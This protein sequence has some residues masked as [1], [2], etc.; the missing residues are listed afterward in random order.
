MTHLPRVWLVLVDLTGDHEDVGV[1]VDVV[2][3]PAS[4]ARPTDLSVPDDAPGGVFLQRALDAG[5]GDVVVVTTTPPPPSTR[6]RVARAFLRDQ[7]PTSLGL[8]DGGQGLA[9][10][11][12]TVVVDPDLDLPTAGA[13]LVRGHLELTIPEAGERFLVLVDR[14]PDL[15]AR[16]DRPEVELL[17]ALVA[18]WPQIPLVLLSSEQARPAVTAPWRDL[19][20]EV[21]GDCPDWGPWFAEHRL[22]FSTVFSVSIR[23]E[24]RF[25]TFLDR[26]QPVAN[27]VLLAHA[28]DSR[29]VLSMEPVLVVREE[30]RGLHGLV[31]LLR[32]RVATSLDRAD[33]VLVATADDRRQ[34]QGL[35]PTKRVVVL[36]D[37]LAGAPAPVRERSDLVVLASPGADTLA[38]HEDAAVLA[39]REVL[40]IVRAQRPGTTLR[41]LADNPSPVV[42]LL[43]QEPGVVVEPLGHDPVGSVASAR[44]LLAPYAH[45]DGARAALSL[46]CAAR[47][48]VLTLAHGATA[49]D[50][51]D[52]WP[53]VVCPDPSALALRAFDLLADQADWEQARAVVDGR[54]ASGGRANYRRALVHALAGLGVAPPLGREL[55]PDGDL[56]PVGAPPP[57]P[58]A[59]M[60]ALTPEQRQ[61]RLVAAKPRTTTAD[62]QYA[63]WRSGHAFTPDRREELM[64]RVE[65]LENPP[66][67]S[68]LVPTYNSEPSVLADTLQSVV[69]QVYP[70]WELCIADDCSPNADTREALKQWATRD[71]RIRVV[72]LEANQGISGATN[73]ALALARGTY[74]AL[75]DHDDLLKPHALA[76]VALKLGAEPE[77]DLVY[78]DEDKLD[79]RG[80]LVEP[81]FKPDWSPEHL[82]SRNYVTHLTV[83][84]TSL[85]AQVGGLRSGFDGSQDHD[86]LL[87]LSELTD[88]VAHLAEP[89]YTWRLVPGSTAAV[90]DAKPYA[91]EA[92]KRA[93]GESLT[94][95]GY[96]GKAVDG[97]L[98]STYRLRYD[99][100]GTPKVT[101]IIPTRNGEHLLRRAIDS[102]REKSTYTNY[103]FLIVD[104]E[105]DDPGSLSYL[106]TYGGK[107]LRYPHR[108]NYARM[109][110]LAA[111]AADGDLLLFL[112]NDTEVIEPGWIEALVEHAQRPEVGAV[113]C[114]LYFPDDRPQHEGVIVN[115]CAGAAGNVDHGGWWGFGDVVRDVTAVTGA[116]TMMRPSVFHEIGGFEERLRIAFNDVDLCLRVRQAGYRVVYTPFATLYHHESATRGYKPHLADDA[117]FDHRW[118]P[119]SEQFHDPFYNVNLDRS[120]PFAIAGEP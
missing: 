21:V 66:L 112:N 91:F 105:S 47:T 5:I 4:L 76:E 35:F 19:G 16:W 43:A 65:A 40:P 117:F 99:V 28:F 102:V 60:I 110:N 25:S 63:A 62:E 109:M 9:A 39:V 72:L 51:G 115:Y 92:S 77:L 114:R 49:L 1:G 87:R 2:V 82:T 119:R 46:A 34:A 59:P 97:I 104:N 90:V 52:T 41:V 57:A 56:A 100:V 8:A 78:T 33:L 95:R 15:A 29:R 14:V 45:G 38:A 61:T 103:E 3:R 106:A 24:H 32:E 23:V 120:R 84:R 31:G 55:L 116:V 108:F 64:R 36:P 50:L 54:A 79:E 53:A 107:V 18:L 58:P 88:R 71:S 13:A 111:W 20:V 75:L 6:G 42:Q 118:V 12:G 11:R 27:R 80:R 44:V 101:I 85:V 89:L 7:A 69:D 113:G 83:A 74:V 96:T 73:A 94:R 30:V 10:P 48:P 67:I 98:P 17:R 93:L 37:A 26:F 70:H 81:F 68:I 22:G 86:L